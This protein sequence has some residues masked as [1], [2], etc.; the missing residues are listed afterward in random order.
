MYVFE[1]ELVELEIIALDFELKFLAENN[2][3]LL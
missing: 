1:L 2:I 3:V